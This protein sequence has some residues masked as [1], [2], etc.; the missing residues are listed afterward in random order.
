MCNG[1]DSSNAF[2]VNFKELLGNGKTN[3][4]PNAAIFQKGNHQRPA[5]V[6]RGTDKCHEPFAELVIASDYNILTTPEMTAYAVVSNIQ[7]N[8]NAS[9]NATANGT[10][11]AAPN[12]TAL[13]TSSPTS[14]SSNNSSQ[15]T[16]SPTSVTTS[17]T[18]AGSVA[19]IS[20]SVLLSIF[21][22]KIL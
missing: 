11:T 18:S 6:Y 7:A 15:P 4:T 12:A 2:T 21:L 10:V 17:T 1:S 5:N 16:P 22:F 13:P 3:T 14:P 9:G 8:A 20:K 19:F